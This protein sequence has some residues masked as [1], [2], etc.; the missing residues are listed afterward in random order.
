LVVAFILKTLF[1]AVVL[2]LHRQFEDRDAVFFYIN[3]GLSRKRLMA[4]TL[5]I[6]FEFL[7]L[8]EILITLCQ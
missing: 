8:L 5:S 7:L 6:D 3:L 2:Y 4:A 1:T